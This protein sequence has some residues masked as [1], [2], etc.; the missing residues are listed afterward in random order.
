MEP[1][2]KTISDRLHANSGV[3]NLTHGDY[4]YKID[5]KS[6]WVWRRM[7]PIGINIHKDWIILTGE[8]RLKILQMAGVI[9]YVLK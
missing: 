9:K 4:L 6:K 8:E 3:I 7:N 5:L 2:N 1:T